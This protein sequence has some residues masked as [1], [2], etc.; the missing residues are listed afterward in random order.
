MGQRHLTRIAAGLRLAGAPLLV[1]TPS[2]GAD[3]A[4]LQDPAA[5]A[6]QARQAEAQEPDPATVEIQRVLRR[7]RDPKAPPASEAA[8]ELAPVARE[9]LPLL[10]EVLRA[11]RVP[12]FGEERAQTLSEVQESIVMHTLA[13]LERATVLAETQRMLSQ[14]RTREAREAAVRILGAV[15]RALD[16]PTLYELVHTAPGVPLERRVEEAFRAAVAALVRR[17]GDALLQF[18]RLWSY[19]PE[20]LLPPLLEG[21]GDAGDARCLELLDEILVRHDRLLVPILTE[22]R[23]VGPS[24]SLDVNDRL[25]VR[26]RHHLEPSRTACRPAVFALATLRDYDSVPALIDLLGHES[27]GLASDAY[28]ALRELTGLDLRADAELWNAWYES[29]LDWIAEHAPRV[30]A[31]LHSPRHADV[32]AAVGELAQRRLFNDTWAVELAP[33]LAHSAPSLRLL[34]AR[35][36]GALRSPY[37]IPGLIEALLDPASDVRDAAHRALRS[38][39]RLDLPP[40]AERWRERLLDTRT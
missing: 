22:I 16:V 33:L 36:L 10:V 8:L 11:R 1:L 23:R 30:L 9:G 3:P 32:A 25:A 17:D 20:T 4:S 28:F 40:D 27:R 34:T 24:R 12:A 19:Q 21:L 5:P 15:G 35:A 39:T 37:V 26:L 6:S 7:A 2:L 38:T 13:G 31:K 14:G 18:D 29:E